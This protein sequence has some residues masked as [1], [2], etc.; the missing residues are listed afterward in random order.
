M[1]KILITT[2]NVELIKEN[3]VYSLVKGDK[4]LIASG[5][6][7]KVCKYL[8]EDKTCGSVLKIDLEGIKDD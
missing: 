8:R 7:A 2:K 3:N 4:T 6:V 1:K 5:N